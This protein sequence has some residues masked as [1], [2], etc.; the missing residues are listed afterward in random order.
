MTDIE[1]D[2]Q[3]NYHMS[4]LFPDFA[5]K[6]YTLIELC[7]A[8]IGIKLRISESIRSIARQEELFNYGRS[9]LGKQIVTY[10]KPG[11]SKHHYGIAVDVY[12]SEPNPSKETWAKIAQIGKELG[13]KP[14]HFFERLKDSPHFEFDT[15]LSS[16]QMYDKYQRAGLRG[17]WS[18]LYN[19]L[20]KANDWSCMPAMM[21]AMKELENK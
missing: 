10:S 7:K 5:S 3:N 9:N 11:L 8:S 12:P 13:L 19:D 21:R 2:K 16:A 20:N 17:V 6:V 18:D 4:L 1:R 14:G 15:K